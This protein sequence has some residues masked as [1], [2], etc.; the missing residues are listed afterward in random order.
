[1]GVI[2]PGRSA[3]RG[4]PGL[5]TTPGQTLQLLSCTNTS[6]ARIQDVDDIWRYVYLWI[7]TSGI[8]PERHSLKYNYKQIMPNCHLIR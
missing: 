8:E 7:L 6:F 3:L 2:L 4:V 5:F 1:M